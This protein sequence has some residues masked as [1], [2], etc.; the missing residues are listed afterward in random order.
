MS[1]HFNNSCMGITK[2][3]AV[4]FSAW[5]VP[6]FLTSPPQQVWRPPWQFLLSINKWMLKCSQKSIKQNYPKQYQYHYSL[7]MTSSFKCSNGVVKFP[8]ALSIPTYKQI[9]RNDNL[10]TVL[11]FTPKNITYYTHTHARTYTCTK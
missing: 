5:F 7:T 1:F 10:V 4:P 6:A 3:E 11:C 8:M 9:F 2:K